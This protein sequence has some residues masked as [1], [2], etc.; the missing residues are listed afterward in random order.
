[1]S[2]IRF[3]FF[4]LPF[5][6]G[7][8]R[9]LP[10]R[11]ERWS[12]AAVRGRNREAE[13]FSGEANASIGPEPGGRLIATNQTL[14]NLIRNAFN[15]QPVSD[16]RRARLDELGPLRHHREDCR[17]RSRREGHDAVPPVHAPAPV[18]ARRSLQDGDP[19]GDAGD[20]G[21]RARRRDRRKTRARNSTSHTGRL[22]SRAQALR[23]PAPRPATN[24]GTR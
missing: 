1:M 23:P 19:L 24:C 18:S 17:C 16:R 21:V 20:A 8:A 12:K 11:Q 15:L 14:L 9:R 13:Q 5:S 7:S 4:V 2:S 3:S 10:G 6:R 22:R